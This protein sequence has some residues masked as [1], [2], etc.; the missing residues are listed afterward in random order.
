[1]DNSEPQQEVQNIG[2]YQVNNCLNLDC[3]VFFSM[4]KTLRNF[5]LFLNDLFK[6][7][8]EDQ[9]MSAGLQGK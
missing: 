5:F 9:Q 1:M 7:V 2:R 6:L 8:A 3:I 4:N